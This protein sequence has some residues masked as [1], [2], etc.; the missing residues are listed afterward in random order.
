MALLEGDLSDAP[1]IQKY[2]AEA[3]ETMSAGESKVLRY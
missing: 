3:V 1:L 2:L